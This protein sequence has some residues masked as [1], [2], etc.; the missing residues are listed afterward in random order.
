MCLPFVWMCVVHHASGAQI[1]IRADQCRAAREMRI[2]LL[3]IYDVREARVFHLYSRT[4]WRLRLSD[5]LK[6]NK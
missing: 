1:H 6:D 5:C 2:T 3:F 4:K